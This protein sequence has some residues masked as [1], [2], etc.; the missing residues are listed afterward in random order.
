[1]VD[2][3]FLLLKNKNLKIPEED[4]GAFDVLVKEKI[5]TVE[6]ADRLKDAKG[7]RNIL[8]H[9][10][11]VVDDTI[12]FESI[13]EELGKDVRLLLEKVEEYLKSKG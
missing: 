2:L 3:T 13:T 7:M 6:L 4:K 9:E 12:V 11:G 10:Y 1:M 5:I 8:A